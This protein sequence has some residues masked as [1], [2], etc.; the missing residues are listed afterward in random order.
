MDT[1]EVEKL[2]NILVEVGLPHL[3]PSF[4]EEKVPPIYFINVMN[5]FVHQGQD[6]IDS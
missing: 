1:S 2:S 4:L 6:G 5:D 3:L